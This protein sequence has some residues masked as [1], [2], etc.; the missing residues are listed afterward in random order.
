MAYLH[1]FRN[2]AFPYDYSIHGFENGS[3]NTLSHNK[4]CE[5]NLCKR[6]N[7]HFVCGFSIYV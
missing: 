4:K 3:R 1:V 5:K 7:A 6:A 2:K